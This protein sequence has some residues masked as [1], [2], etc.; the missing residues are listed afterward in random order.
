MK[1]IIEKVH[2][3]ID[4][5]NIGYYHTVG[6]YSKNNFDTFYQYFNAPDKELRKHSFFLFMYLLG[7]LNAGHTGVLSS[8]KQYTKDQEN[9][10]T[11]YDFECYVEAF[12]LHHQQLQEVFPNIFHHTV[13]FLS[14]NEEVIGKKYEYYYRDIPKDLLYKLRHKILESNEHM[15]DMKQLPEMKYLLHEMDIEPFFKNDFL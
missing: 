4:C 2:S 3:I 11:F 9:P 15:K 7:N 1:E 14:N 8:R 10:N 6:N 5:F 13:Y 12:L